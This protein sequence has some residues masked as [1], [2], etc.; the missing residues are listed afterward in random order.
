MINFNSVWKLLAKISFVGENSER[1]FQRWKNHIIQI[2][3]QVEKKFIGLDLNGKTLMISNVG[4]VRDKF[5]CKFYHNLSNAIYILDDSCN[6]VMTEV[7]WLFFV[8]IS[9]TR[10]GK[11]SQ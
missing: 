3:F 4:T 9:K 6:I 10:Q 1:I 2:N 7:V 8:W 5:N 11:Q